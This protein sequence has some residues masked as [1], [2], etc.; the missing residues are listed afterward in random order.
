M[1]EFVHAMPWRAAR[2]PIAA[3]EAGDL[4]TRLATPAVGVWTG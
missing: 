2:S 1:G 4:Q 3:V